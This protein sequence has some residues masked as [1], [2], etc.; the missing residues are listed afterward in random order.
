MRTL[1]A[2][3]LAN[4]KLPAVFSTSVEDIPSYFHHDRE[5]C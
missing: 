5:L 4:D 2:E 1:F 3:K